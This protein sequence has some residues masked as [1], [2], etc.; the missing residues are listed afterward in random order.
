MAPLGF[1]KKKRKKRLILVP[2]L[3]NCS[4]LNPL[5]RPQISKLVQK[6]TLTKKNIN[7]QIKIKIKIPTHS[8]PI[9]Y[10]NL[11]KQQQKFQ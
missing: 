3:Q 2:H 4:S 7:K 9:A 10:P 5:G 6:D 11:Y 1:W 8:L